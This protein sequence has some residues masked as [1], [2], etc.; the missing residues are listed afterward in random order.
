MVRGSAWHKQSSYKTEGVGGQFVG[1]SG[2]N[3]I[4]RIVFA[5]LC[6][7]RRMKFKNW[8]VLGHSP[9]EV[10][11]PNVGFLIYSHEQK[12]SIVQTGGREE[13]HCERR[14]VRWEVR[15]WTKK[16]TDGVEHQS[17][18]KVRKP[19]VWTPEYRTDQ[20]CGLMVSADT[21]SP[22]RHCIGRKKIRVWTFQT[23]FRSEDSQL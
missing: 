12:G 2:K 3:T 22:I 18:K 4:V 17:K 9:G 10:A 23:R 16:G 8:P 15:V 20:G 14:G 11:C 6:A 1:G 13:R 19:H 21:L 5:W 7:A